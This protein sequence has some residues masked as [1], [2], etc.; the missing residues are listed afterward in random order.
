MIA[1]CYFV[2]CVHRKVKSESDYHKVFFVF[3]DPVTSMSYD[4]VFGI[5]QVLKHL[6]ISTQ[7]VVSINPSRIDGNMYKRPKLLIMTHS[8]YFFNVSL[9][10]KVVHESAAFALNAQPD[11]HKVSRMDKYIAPFQLQ[12]KEIYEVAN[13]KEPDHG[14]GNTI[15]SILEAVGR[16][17]RPDKSKH[18]S[19]FIDFLAGDED[20]KLRSVMINSLSH[21]SYYD[22]TPAP[23]DLKLA[24]DETLA[25]VEKY[26]A[27]QLEIVRM[28]VDN[29]R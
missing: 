13:G 12:L 8:S 25:V 22:E 6:S 19:E 11:G 24:C 3:D 18:L 1:F 4:Y 15:R 2:A 10:N 23:D 28:V 14:T 27:G 26:A 9:T 17:C 21:G 5:A 7:G 29:R 20:I 16:F